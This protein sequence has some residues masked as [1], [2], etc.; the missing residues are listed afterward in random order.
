V[1]RID[2]VSRGHRRSS[3]RCLGVIMVAAL[4]MV[5]PAE[6]SRTDDSSRIHE[7]AKNGDLAKVTALLNSNPALVFDRDVDGRTPLHL[8]AKE[9]H[10]DIVEMLLAH[11]AEVNAGDASGDTALSYAA[12][13]GHL[14]VA[15]VLLDHKANVN[16][17][18]SMGM[19]PLDRALMDGNKEMAEL[20]RRHGGKK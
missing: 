11:G 10:E 3:I 17:R 13:G 7:A 16:S 12:A 4:C 15:Q 9:G 20:L 8:A 14:D 1:S 2:S 6:C 19:T 5:M 18:G